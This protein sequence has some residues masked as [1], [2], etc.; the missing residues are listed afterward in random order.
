MSF[1][2]FFNAPRVGD[3]L[4]HPIALARL[5]HK[6]TTYR[7]IVIDVG[8]GSG[9][10]IDYLINKI[11]VNVLALDQ[12][13]ALL[14]KH[15][16]TTVKQSMHN[17]IVTLG[18]ALNPMVCFVKTDVTSPWSLSSAA[19]GSVLH[20]VLSVIPDPILRNNLLAGIYN[21]LKPGGIFSF[22]D[23]IIDRDN[24]VIAQHYKFGKPLIAKGITGYSP[25]ILENSGGEFVVA[26]TKKDGS[27]STQHLYLPL[28]KLEEAI[29][30]GQLS[31]QFVATHKT[32]E[33]YNEELISSGFHVL[34]STLLSLPG[35]ADP[36][37][38]RKC[39][40]ITAQK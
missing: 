6:K 4:C 7:P 5:Q 12:D 15:P 8:T 38:I 31:L 33:G 30:D 25:K 13:L 19:D 20:R 18:K 35:I 17:A 27:A 37:P 1:G 36:S 26:M 21:A 23:F 29:N 22:I 14:E 3:D 34:E 10:N 40:R 24:P 16:N 32:V 9:Q 39:I 11:Q 2:A 28:E